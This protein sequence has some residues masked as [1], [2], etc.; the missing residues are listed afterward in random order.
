MSLLSRVRGTLVGGNDVRALQSMKGDGSSS[1]FGLG[2]D[3]VQ[4][5]VC[6]DV[7]P[8]VQ[9]GAFDRR[10]VCEQLP[11]AT[12]AGEPLDSA[13]LLVTQHDRMAWAAVVYG[14]RARG[15]VQESGDDSGGYEGLI[16]ERDDHLGGVR[17]LR[18]TAAERCRLAVAPLLANHRLG[19]S[20][21][22][23]CGDLRRVRAE[24]DHDSRELWRGALR[25]DRVFEK[26]PACELGQQLRVRAKATALA[27]GEDQ[28][29]K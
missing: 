15:C 21:V 23:R 20:E 4:V 11:G 3:R 6:V 8:G 22:D 12:V 19:S 18:E 28:P 17:E 16:P 5:L 10:S 25:A 14:T 7:A 2:T 1:Q 29:G 26:W 24:H 9:V 13:R 27:S